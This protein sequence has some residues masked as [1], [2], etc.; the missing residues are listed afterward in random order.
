MKTVGAGWKTK[1]QRQIGTSKGTAVKRMEQH[2]R[3]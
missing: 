1:Q 3:E 2:E